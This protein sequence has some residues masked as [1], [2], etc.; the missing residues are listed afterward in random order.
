MASNSNAAVPQGFSIF[1]PMI[2]APLQFFPAL[3]TK[4]LDDLVNAYVTGPASI[5]EKRTTVSIDFLDYAQRTGATF[6]FYA[7]PGFVAAAESP[8]SFHD[9]MA[10]SL[11]VSPITPTWDWASAAPSTS[12]SHNMSRK[13]STTSSRQQTAGDFANLPGMKIMTKDGLDVTNTA[14]RGCK[15]K[16][17]RD[18]AHLMRIIKACDSC[19]RKKIRCDPSHKKRGASQTTAAVSPAKPSKKARVSSRHSAVAPSQPLGVEQFSM[20]MPP[21][22][23][24]ADASFAFSAGLDLFDFSAAGAAPWEDLLA[25]NPSAGQ[26]PDYDFFVDPEGYLSTPPSSFSDSQSQSISPQLPDQ[27]PTGTDCDVSDVDLAHQQ[28]LEKP[29]PWFALPAEG[30]ASAYTDFNL[31]SPRSSFSEDERMVSL[32]S[33]SP[34]AASD[35]AVSRDSL[36][37]HMDQQR[38]HPNM[39]DEEVVID[40]G[41]A[42]DSHL[43]RHGLGQPQLPELWPY[44]NVLRDGS[45]SHVDPKVAVAPDIYD[46]YE[47]QQAST[48]ALGGLG[49]LQTEPEMTR[50]YNAAATTQ[51]SLLSRTSSIAEQYAEDMGTRTALTDT[52]SS[53]AGLNARSTTSQLGVRACVT[54]SSAY[55]LT[56]WK[57]TTSSTVQRWIASTSS[58]AT[59]QTIQPIS[60][61]LPPSSTA[62]A[63]TDPS[64]ASY[65]GQV[66]ATE[67]T[68]VAPVRRPWYN[69]SNVPAPD[70]PAPN[71]HPSATDALR[72]VHTIQDARS[73]V[74]QQQLGQTQALVSRF[75][76]SSAA[77]QLV[78]GK[79][80]SV[81]QEATA[82]RFAHIRSHLLRSHAPVP[83][84]I[85]ASARQLTAEKSV[86][87]NGIAALGEQAF[88]R[89]HHSRKLQPKVPLGDQVTALGRAAGSCLLSSTSAPLSSQYLLVMVGLL[90]FF[91]SSMFG[92]SG[93]LS[94]AVT[95][96]ALAM[97]ARQHGLRDRSDSADPAHGPSTSPCSVSLV[98]LDAGVSL[99]GRSN[100]H[101]EGVVGSPKASTVEQ[102]L[103]TLRCQVSGLSLLPGGLKKVARSSFFVR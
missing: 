44:A 59:L 35:E 6:K 48:N 38:V 64:C 72:Q 90:L 25:Y 26:E 56:P 15:T 2:G 51:S 14:S 40:D 45:T 7:V 75:R 102:R 23:I 8:A 89:G 50:M 95:A 52:T 79:G 78:V 55:P 41:S 33:A 83:H 67:T 99:G 66:P 103:A 92:L 101:D 86:T 91:C 39:G 98:T 19:K 28:Q 47:F 4:H 69:D 53:P 10:S 60:T 87:N 71:L 61:A 84:A 57:T 94:C 100:S 81:Q 29:E 49:Q 13:T 77:A 30:D 17:Q 5:K 32:S 96:A 36:L 3:G 80:K 18:H 63:S 34:S 97:K 31:Y 9:S 1:Q 42:L 68:T 43:A 74:H 85:S 24:D 82:T 70:Q 58:A 16:E 27:P 62:D 65:G 46:Q 11:N 93:V 12:S 22:P 54:K 76:S 21:P 20:P 88:R 37:A 73:S